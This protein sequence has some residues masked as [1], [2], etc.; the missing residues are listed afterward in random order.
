MRGGNL[1][2]RIPQPCSEDL[3]LFGATFHLSQKIPRLHLTSGE[4]PRELAFRKSLPM[5]SHS[6][7]GPSANQ[8]FLSPI[9]ALIARQHAALDFRT[10]NLPQ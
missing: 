3:S 10:L 4:Y 5:M 8:R 9:Q 6:I 1:S 7:S 2:H